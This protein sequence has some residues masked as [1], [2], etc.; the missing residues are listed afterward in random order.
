MNKMTINLS[1]LEYQ[2]VENNI[3]MK[4]CGKSK[5]FVRKTSSAHKQ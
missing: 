3:I 5:K 1:T 4:T 2:E